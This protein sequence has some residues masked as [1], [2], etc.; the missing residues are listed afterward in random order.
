[1]PVDYDIAS[2]GQDYWQ[3]RDKFLIACRLLPGRLTTLLHPLHCEDQPL[4]TDLFWLGDE[5][6][7]NVLV[8]ISATHGVEGFCGSAAQVNWLRH[9]VLPDKVAVLFIH[10]LNPFGFAHLRRVN[11]DNID[12][13]RNFID[14][15]QVPVNE[16]YRALADVLLP[17]GWDESSFSDCQQALAEFRNKHGQRKTEEAVSG[18][19]YH[20]P[21]GLFYGGKAPSWSRH[22]IEQLIQDYQLTDR[23]KVAVV[24]IH[25]GLG[26]YGYGEIICDHPPHTPGAA[27]ARR[28]FGDSVTEPAL[29]TSTSVPKS[30]LLDYAWQQ[31]LGDK[32]C[33]VTLE[34]GTYALEEMFEVLRE[35]NYV[36]QKEGAS[37]SLSNA[38]KRV[39]QRLRGYFYPDK[40]DWKEMVLFR[41]SQVLA[42]ALRGLQEQDGLSD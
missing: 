16:G 4:A 41:S 39:Q 26:P 12:L 28:W 42:Q 32:V 13:N 17:S 33:Y 14:F 30:G 34:F 5:K 21:G 1:M 8:I 9:E 23:K 2:F 27:R 19:Q 18:G 38:I 40:T 29:G 36:W 15:N 20:Y 25:S 11:E 37:K 6:A 24:D 3:A 7:E 22:N 10:A 35:E 31:A